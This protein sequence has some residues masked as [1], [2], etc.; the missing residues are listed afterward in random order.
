[1]RYKEIKAD[2]C[3]WDGACRSVLELQNRKGY[4]Q[5]VL[6]NVRTSLL[7]M[8]NVLCVNFKKGSHYAK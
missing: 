6:R 8:N 4:M 7:A 5:R 2:D 1:M 3:L